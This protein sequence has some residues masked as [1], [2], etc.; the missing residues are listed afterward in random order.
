MEAPSDY[1]TYPVSFE[2]G[3]LDVA[4]VKIIKTLKKAGFSA[5]LVGGCVRDLLL[6]QSPKDFDVVTDAHPK[7]IKKLF[8]RCFIIGRRFQLVHVYQ[9]REYIEV[10]TFRGGGQNEFGTMGSDVWRRDF[11]I[12]ALYYDLSSNEVIDYVGGWQDLKKKQLRMI[13]DPSQRFQEDPL[14]LL[15]AIRFVSKLD[16]ELEAT[17]DS[18][19]V[20][21]QVLLSDV[22]PARL[23]DEL[24]K[25]F[26]TGHAD[27][28]YLKLDQLDYF[29]ALFPATVAAFNSAKRH[30]YRKLIRQ[31]M[32]ATDARFD[33]NRPLN[34]GFLL[35]V[36]GWPILQEN[37]TSLYKKKYARFPEALH[38]ALTASLRAMTMNLAIPKRF[39]A[40]VRSV[41]IL[42][43]QMA[44]R[45][46]KKASPLLEHRYI[47]AG[48]DFME[49]RAKVGGSLADLPQ[50]WRDFYQ[51]NA[52]P[53]RAP[54]HKRK[55]RS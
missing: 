15:R 29:Q 53:L 3:D 38:H 22:A 11:T 51:S 46:K 19:M 32:L 28:A 42:Q 21:S 16:F 8:K 1:A 14:R 48:I 5:F 36:I 37:L 17:M 47:R 55:K 13:G 33:E 4:A 34:P 41:W 25:L 43:Y 7:Q 2:V 6:S 54:A 10:S 50:W 49:L 44:K 23:F 45:Q 39:I 35:A 40:M 52:K 24:I 26:F 30:F 9:G 27:A 12:N 20:D 31:A 18:A